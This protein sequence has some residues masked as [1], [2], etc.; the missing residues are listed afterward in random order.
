MLK[1]FSPPMSGRSPPER[2]ANRRLSAS[3]QGGGWLVAGRWRAAYLVSTWPSATS[4]RHVGDDVVAGAILAKDRRGQRGR[5]FERLHRRRL[6]S[7]HHQ[8]RE[9]A[10]DA[11]VV[12]GERRAGLRVARDHPA[13][14]RA[15]VGEVGGEREHGHDLGG[16]RDREAAPPR[17][18]LARLLRHLGRREPHFDLAEVAVVR[19]CD[20]LPRHRRRVDVEAAERLDLGARHRAGVVGRDAELGKACAHRRLEGAFAVAILQGVVEEGGRGRLLV[21]DARVDRRGEQVRGGDRVDVARHVQVE[22]LH[23]CAPSSRRPPRRP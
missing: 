13:E 10:G 6:Q 14:A 1:N 5:A 9:R 20:A 22:L 19:V 18:L 16:H 15:E 12:G 17:E 2:R 4:R 3:P 11:E 23:R 7:F 8:H 21:E